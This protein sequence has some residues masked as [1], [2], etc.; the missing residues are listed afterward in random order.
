MHAISGSLAASVHAHSDAYLPRQTAVH[1]F[2][3]SEAQLP[4]WVHVRQGRQT[5]LLEISCS[6]NAST[7]TRACILCH[8]SHRCFKGRRRAGIGCCGTDGIIAAGDRC[9][10]RNSTRERGPTRVRGLSACRVAAMAAGMPFKR[11]SQATSL[12]SNVFE[13]L[14]MYQGQWQPARP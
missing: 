6:I 12:R 4:A 13:P 14:H 2:T 10:W 8:A 3:L 9:G 5:A 11:T 7:N 1:A